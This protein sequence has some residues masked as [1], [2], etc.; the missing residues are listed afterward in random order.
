[1][2]L[3]MSWC[4]LGFSICLISH[5]FLI[6]HSFSIVQCAFNDVCR[7]I[8][9]EALYNNGEV[10]VQTWSRKVILMRMRASKATAR[11]HT[12]Y[13]Y[14]QKSRDARLQTESLMMATVGRMRV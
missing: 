12:E 3:R 6:W 1:M 14:C 4:F 11:C 7:Y 2:F 9:R 5:W 10:V 13:Y 8:I